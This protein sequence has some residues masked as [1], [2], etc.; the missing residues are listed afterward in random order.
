MSLTPK[1]LSLV[2]PSSGMTDL[3]LVLVEELLSSSKTLF[4]TLHALPSLPHTPRN[5]SGYG[6][7]STPTSC[8][9][10]YCTVHL[11]V[12]T[13]FTPHYPKTWT[14]FYPLI[15]TLSSSYVV[16]SIVIMPVG[17]CGHL[18]APAMAL[19][20]KTSETHWD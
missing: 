7:P 3:S 20:Q 6:F 12:M 2:T 9:Y 17:G 5:T 16:T 19:Q 8:L 15:R 13:P 11:T 14:N 18:S 10:V 1:Y 4:L